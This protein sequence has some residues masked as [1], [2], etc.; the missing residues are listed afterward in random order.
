VNTGV[1]G[2]ILIG[3][4]TFLETNEM[5]KIMIAVASISVL[6]YSSAYAHHCHRHHHRHRCCTAAPS[7][8]CGTV[9]PGCASC[10]ATAQQSG[11]TPDPRFL[12]PAPQ[13]AEN[14]PTPKPEDEW[15]ENP[16]MNRG[17]MNRGGH[18]H[19]NPANTDSHKKAAPHWQGTDRNGK[20]DTWEDH[21]GPPMGAGG[22]NPPLKPPTSKPVKK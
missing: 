4:T 19:H 20:V 7:C 5:I 2:R 17:D 22:P 6:S 14:Y 18:P 15:S 13:G 3:S 10:G 8:G 11:P 9:Q 16:D 21:G 12:A 1:S